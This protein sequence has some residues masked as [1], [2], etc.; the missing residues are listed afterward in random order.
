MTPRR[1]VG[2]PHAI[3]S[4]LDVAR[5]CARAGWPV[6]PLAARRK[7]PAGN[8]RACQEPGHTHV[9][10]PCPT[11]GRWCHGFH[12]ATLDP[13]LI[14]TWWTANP[15][16]GVAVSCGPAGLVVIDVDAHHQSVPARD[17]V[18][19]G[20]PIGDTVDLHGLASGFHTLALLA[21]LRGQPD[22][23]GDENTLRVRTP[24][25]GLHIWYLGGNRPWLSSAGSGT[26]RA[27][28]WQVDVRAGGGYIIAPG[29]VTDAGSY[30]AIGPCR[31]PAP[32]PDWLAEE[33]ARTGHLETPRPAHPTAPVVPPRG[34]QAVVAAG[35]HRDGASRA[36]AGVLA[37]V[38]DCAMLPEGAAFS[39][40]LN[41]AAFTAGG[42]VAAGYLT[43]GDAE[44]AL[45]ETAAGA[46]P[47]QDR[48]C[49]QIVRSGMNAG[50]RRPLHPGGR[51]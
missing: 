31:R 13:Q 18:L 48:R 32:L 10:C 1:A 49:A 43:A 38:A 36:L 27:L 29:T 40:K 8:C 17:R 44:Q 7:I 37:A 3:P 30:S 42:L 35:G 25:G 46:R 51:P 34:R 33:L 6:H 26:N 19:P 11:T 12:A 22:P 39:E 21:A 41:R 20:I 4:P 9:G 28:A 5:W 16:F 15:F 2:D 23:S 50:A 45:L 47:G 14:D 24:S